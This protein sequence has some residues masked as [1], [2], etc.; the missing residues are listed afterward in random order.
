VVLPAADSFCNYVTFGIL[1]TFKVCINARAP[2]WQGGLLVIPRGW[3]GFVSSPVQR[4]N[5]K[6]KVK[7][8]DLSL[9]HLVIGGVKPG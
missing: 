4:R 9:S 2:H 6:K 1:G 8:T 5:K 3:L 7:F